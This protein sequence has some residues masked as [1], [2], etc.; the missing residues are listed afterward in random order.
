MSPSNCRV[1]ATPDFASLSILAQESGA[2]DAERC[3]D[4]SLVQACNHRG[5]CRRTARQEF[6]DAKQLRS[7][8]EAV[9][10]GRWA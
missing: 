9:T 2:P 4:L 8:S 3:V 6:G 1:Q 10:T 7:R 5:S